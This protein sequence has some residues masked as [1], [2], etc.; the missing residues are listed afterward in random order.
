MYIGI[1]SDGTSFSEIIIGKDKGDFRC[2]LSQIEYWLSSKKLLND[3]QGEQSGR[4]RNGRLPKAARKTKQTTTSA[5]SGRGQKERLDVER[6]RR[7][8]TVQSKRDARVQPQ[9]RSR[10]QNK[11]IR[12]KEGPRNPGAGDTPGEVTQKLGELDSN[13]R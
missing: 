10:V 9:G 4:T 11:D 8:V 12:A 6:E 7:T 3:G 13:N 2:D 5:P 1:T